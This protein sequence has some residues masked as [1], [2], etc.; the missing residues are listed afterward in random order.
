MSNNLSRRSLHLYIELLRGGARRSLRLA[1]QYLIAWIIRSQLVPPGTGSATHGGEFQ[2]A[3]DAAPFVAQVPAAEVHSVH[4]LTTRLSARFHA[5][6]GAVNP[7]VPA[8]LEVRRGG[9]RRSA[10]LGDGF[11]ARR[12]RG[13]NQESGRVFAGVA[14]RQSGTTKPVRRSPVLGFVCRVRPEIDYEERGVPPGY[15]RR[16]AWTVLRICAQWRVLGRERNARF[17][18]RYGQRFVW[19]VKK[20]AGQT[21]ANS[22]PSSSSVRR[23]ER[24]VRLAG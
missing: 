12:P 7:R 8:E 14:G 18:T 11:E 15:A 9:S 19:H 20:Q 23:T 2:P 3:H 6:V 17:A 4:A 1:K 10:P 16:S 22:T 21:Q 13:V 24:P 5:V